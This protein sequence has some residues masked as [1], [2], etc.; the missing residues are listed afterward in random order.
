M[1]RADDGGVTIVVPASLAADWL[2]WRPLRAKL[3]S[4]ADVNNEDGVSLD[5][6]L[7]LNE[8]LDLDDELQAKA[9]RRK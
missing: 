9:A 5:E 3:L 6:L 7:S 8:L 4:W 1:S 2:V